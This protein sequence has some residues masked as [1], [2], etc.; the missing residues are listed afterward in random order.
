M[1]LPGVAFLEVET[2]AVPQQTPLGSDAHTKVQHF[3]S[4]NFVLNAAAT[5]TF[6]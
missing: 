2:E 1:A 5:F 6:I 4:A 3:R